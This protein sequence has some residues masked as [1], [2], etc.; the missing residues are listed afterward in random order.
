MWQ[1]VELPT[2]VEAHKTLDKK[3]LFKVGDLHQVRLLG[4]HIHV[5]PCVTALPGIGLWWPPAM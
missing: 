5:S 1:L 3:F 4:M 2:V